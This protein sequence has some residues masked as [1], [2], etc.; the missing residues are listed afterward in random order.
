MGLRTGHPGD[1]AMLR[2]LRIAALT[3]SPSAFGSTLQREHAR[4]VDDWRRWFAPGVTFF[5]VD[6][7]GAGGGLIAVVAGGD[8]NQVD[9]VSMWV[10]PD[11]RG[12][13][14][15]D[16]LVAAVVAWTKER[17]LAVWLYVVEGN[18][19]AMSLYARHG[20][21]ATGEIKVRSD[22]VRELEMA[23]DAP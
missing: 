16:A 12:K 6:E 1:E 9:L 5:W 17:G 14:V 4:T 19:P 11:Q 18:L 21:R 22:G 13:G 23:Y 2:D 8:S 10:R 3:D 20:F 15:G 7:A